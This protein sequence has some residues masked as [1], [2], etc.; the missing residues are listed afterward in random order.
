MGCISILQQARGVPRWS[1]D[2]LSRGI[3]GLFRLLPRSWARHVPRSLARSDFG[4]TTSRPNPSQTEPNLI[5]QTERPDG[6][7]RGSK[8]HAAGAK[9]KRLADRPGADD[10]Q[11]IAYATSDGDGRGE[12]IGSDQPRYPLVP[13][14]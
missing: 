1:V 6:L 4:L 13:L 9:R 2:D 14:A 10:C 7:G 3:G 12:R 5:E 11:I 8:S